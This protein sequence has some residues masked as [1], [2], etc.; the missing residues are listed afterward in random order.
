MSNE[1][2]T[3]KIVTLTVSILSIVIISLAATIWIPYDEADKWATASKV[4]MITFVT[5]SSFIFTLVILLLSE[6]KLKSLS[7]GVYYPPRIMFNNKFNNMVNLLLSPL[8]F[9]LQLTFFVL[10]ITLMVVFLLA[11]S[12]TLLIFSGIINYK[13]GVIGSEKN[14]CKNKGGKFINNLWKRNENRVAFLT[15]QYE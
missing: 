6:D 2:L 12:I 10:Y 11:N 1:I 7:K 15:I 8:Y 4:S 14:S 9:V 13:N 3:Y 5:I